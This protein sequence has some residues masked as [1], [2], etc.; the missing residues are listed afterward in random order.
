[1]CLDEIGP[2]GVGVMPD[3][4]DYWHDAV[5]RYSLWGNLMAGG[6]GCEW[7]M[8][9]RYAHNDLNCEDWRSRDH[10]WDLTKIALDFFHTLPFT[11]MQS[12][13]DI[14]SCTKDYVFAKPG[15]VYVIYIPTGG[16]TKIELPK[17]KYTVKWFSPLLGGEL[18]A[19]NVKEIHG[20]GNFC[21]GEPP[22]NSQIDWVVLIK[23]K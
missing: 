8:G 16:K 6:A 19:G 17:G 15:E 12:M 13:D 14:T 21:T 20:P 4:D 23:K 18:Q 7:Y 9:Y 1:V 11:E 5:R 3:G 10:M 2:A 22:Y